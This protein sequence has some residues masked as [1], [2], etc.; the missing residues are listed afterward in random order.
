[1][2]YTFERAELERVK[3]LEQKKAN[4]ERQ[5]DYKDRM[6]GQGFTQVTGWVHE[7]Q[8]ADV[9]VLLHFLQANPDFMVGPARNT[10]TGRLHK[11]R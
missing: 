6:A 5:R 10:K 4:A 2:L 3:K 11:L 8:R 1:M 9:I 7:D